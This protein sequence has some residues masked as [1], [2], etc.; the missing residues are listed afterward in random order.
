MHLSLREDAGN[1]IDNSE[2]T[3]WKSRLGALALPTL[4]AALLAVLLLLAPAGASAADSGEGAPS[5]I[6]PSSARAITP[7]APIGSQGVPG[8]QP[9][10]PGA[11]QTPPG[12]PQ[13]PGDPL[14]WIFI[15][16]GVLG[17][18]L[19]IAWAVLARRAADD[20]PQDPA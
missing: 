13:A 5:A 20:D 14:T 12:P 18:A 2:F 8:M 4:S 11:S 17:V 19:L 3:A 9:A 1:V 10:A 6:T 15:V 16:F 7:S